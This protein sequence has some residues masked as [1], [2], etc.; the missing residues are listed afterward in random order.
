MPDT[1]FDRLLESTNLP[2]PEIAERLGYNVRTLYRLR[3]GQRAPRRAEVELLQQLAR[4]RRVTSPGRPKFRFID[5]FA[6]I[7]GMRLGAETAGGRCVF[8]CERNAHSRQTY[9]AN[10]PCEAHEFAEDIEDVEPADV[11]DHDLLLAG[12][13]CQPFSIAG[14]SKKNAL[15]RPHGFDCKEQGNLFFN[16]VNILKAK[17]PAGFVLENVKNLKTHDGGTTFGVIMQHLTSP[18]LSYSVQTRVINAKGYV[19]QNRERIFIV[20]FR[21]AVP[22]DLTALDIPDPNDGPKLREILHPEDGSEEADERYTVG[23]QAKVA[24]KYIL[25]EH[26]WDYLQRYHEKHKAAGNGFG[27]GLVGK[28]DTART[29]SARYFKDGSEILIRRGRG[30]PRRLTPRECARLMGFDTDHHKFII[31]VSD[32]QAYKQFGNAVVVPVVAAV[33]RFVVPQ[34]LKVMKTGEPYQLDIPLDAR[35]PAAR[36]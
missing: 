3:N 28:N 5:L 11:P 9:H 12:F 22:F 30:R 7:G 2:L 33:V 13:P 35:P 21:E 26:L 17:R 27:F 36:G 25:T 10:F 8:T 32:T 34:L 15:G 20:G 18:P 4:T 19:P 23:P 14:V 24:P 1:A 29:L 16:I 31:P 6:G